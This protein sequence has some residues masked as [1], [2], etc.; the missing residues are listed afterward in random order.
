MPS[1]ASSKLKWESLL[2]ES[3]GKKFGRLTVL[4]DSGFTKN[5]RK[6]WRFRCECGKETSKAASS[7]IKGITRSCGCLM[8]ETATKTA[9]LKRVYFVAHKPTVTSWRSMMTR[10]FNPDPKRYGS[11]R[12]FYAG[13]RPC[14]GLTER[15][16]N[17]VT[18]IGLRPSGKTLDRIDGKHGYHCGICAQCKAEEWPTNIRW[19][20]P[21]EQAQNTKRNRVVTVAGVSK[22]VSQWAREI[23]VTPET[24][25][26]RIKAGDCPED[27]IREA[28]KP[29][30]LSESCSL[31]Q[32]EPLAA[33]R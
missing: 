15:P 18:A 32:Q 1:L 29:R 5:G 23:G 9:K 22:C 4:A 14:A 30:V 24:I 25:Y 7:V 3:V 6:S 2:S 27:A 13:I 11:I 33:I 12:Y 20:T 19:S 16:E 26:S 31:A 10:C 21:V 28:G 17:L 8:R